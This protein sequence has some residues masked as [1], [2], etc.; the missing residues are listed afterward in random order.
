[1]PAILITPWMSSTPTMFG[2][3]IP[4]TLARAMQIDRETGTTYWS[5]AVYKEMPRLPVSE[6][7]DH[8]Q[9]PSDGCQ[10]I[11]LRLLFSITQ[12]LERRVRFVHDP[13]CDDGSCTMAL[14]S[15]YGFISIENGQTSMI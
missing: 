6:L 3:E 12:R 2:V 10:Y 11:K 9:D 4:T 1:M 7:L 13:S 5:D 14:I 15:S 8:N